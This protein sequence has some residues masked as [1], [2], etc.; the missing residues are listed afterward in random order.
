MPQTIDLREIPNRC[1][2]VT[3]RKDRR[4]YMTQLAKNIHFPIEFFP[5]MMNPNTRKGCLE[6]HLAVIENAISR[7]W[8]KVLILEDDIEPTGSF[9]KY[10]SWE[11]ENVPDDWDMIYLGGTVK[12]KLYDEADFQNYVDLQNREWIRMCCWTTHAYVVN[13]EN[14]A[15]IDDIRRAREQKDQLDQ[16]YLD[17]IHTKY[18]CYMHNPMIFIQR[19][20]YSDIEKA[21]VN[22]TF[23]EQTIQGFRTPIHEIKD[24]NYILKLDN[25]TD[26]ELPPITLVTVTRNRRKLFPMALRNFELFNYPAD[27]LRW[28]IVDDTPV[29]DSTIDDLLP[30]GDRRIR[31]I[32]TPAEKPMTIA[33]K[34]NIGARE[35]TTEYI[36]HMDDDDYYPPESVLSRVKILMKYKDMGIGCVGCS[37][38]GTYDL[39][40]NKSSMASDGSISLSEAS[41]GYVKSFWEE[42]RFDETAQRGEYWGFIQNRLDRIMDIPYMAVF[43]A[44]THKTNVTGNMRKTVDAIRYRESQQEANFYDMWDDETQSFINSLRKCIDATL[45]VLKTTEERV[46][47]M[48]EQENKRRQ[49]EVERNLRNRMK[50]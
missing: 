37:R 5:V 3:K 36:L 29:S 34:R 27:K 24:G 18:R 7:G 44:I 11:L 4:K 2:N 26:E 45:P 48:E 40:E 9:D 22:Y 39:I 46:R 1:I 30:T 20:G 35:A 31:H 25:T 21:E 8:T 42:R 47:E 38:Y 28:I 32:W 14:A 6:S 49:E 13:L 16:Y 10:H 43:Y 41:M 12:Q 17:K 33:A 50:K 15:L 19:Q 23:M